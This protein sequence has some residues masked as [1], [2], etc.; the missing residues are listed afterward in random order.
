[1]FFPPLPHLL[2]AVLGLRVHAELIKVREML[3]LPA[4][5]DLKVLVDRVAELLKVMGK[6]PK[7]MMVMKTK[8]SV[9][10]K[11]KPK[12]SRILRSRDTLVHILRR[13][14]G[15]TNP[16]EVAL[17]RDGTQYIV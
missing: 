16:S 8:V 5:H 7:V 1:M 9:E 3:E 6:L 2:R 15:D 4:S 13:I 14:R 11:G 12:Q 17:A 10:E